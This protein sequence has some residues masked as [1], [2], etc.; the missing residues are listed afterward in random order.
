VK[1]AA[2]HGYRLPGTF[3][4]QSRFYTDPYVHTEE[5][6]KAALASDISDT[7]NELSYL[8]D[9]FAR[10]GVPPL[11]GVAVGTAAASAPEGDLPVPERVTLHWLFKHVSFGGWIAVAATA[12]T[13]LLVGAAI[14]KTQWFES[15]VDWFRTN[16]PG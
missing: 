13:L 7:E 9:Q 10:Y 5:A 15:L 11:I 3:D 2:A 8:V 12:L 6:S 14:G 16:W 4:S 1:E